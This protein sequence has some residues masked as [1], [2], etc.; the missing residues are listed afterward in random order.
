MV[1]TKYASS[2]G[3]LSIYVLAE[4]DAF[5]SINRSLAMYHASLRQASDTLATPFGLCDELSA[6]VRIRLYRA[7]MAG[8]RRLAAIPAPI[9][10]IR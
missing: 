8:L 9:C 1:L 10:P 7:L 3:R 5:D 4:H 6:F 2:H